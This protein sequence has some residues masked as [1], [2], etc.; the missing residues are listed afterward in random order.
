MT[1]EASLVDILKAALAPTPVHWGWAPLESAE[2]PPALALVTVRRQLFS[3][4]GYADMC[5]TGEI[6][7]D[8]T[9]LVHVWSRE[10]EPARD[11][12][13]IVRSTIQVAGGWSLQTEVDLYEPNF[14]AWQI[15]AQWM[16][17]GVTPD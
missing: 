4:S 5:E 11:L 12:M 8:T 16:A 3:T 7:G 14:R 6:E 10:Y 17:G 9:I 1:D 2:L 13:Q 15:E